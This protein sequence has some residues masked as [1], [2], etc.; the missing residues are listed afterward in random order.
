[1]EE[2]EVRGTA[3]QLVVRGDTIEYNATAFK[4]AENAMVEDLMKRLPGVEIA[5]DGKITINGQEINK[6]RVDG[7]KFFDGDIEMATKN[8][9]AEMIDKIQV[10]EQKSEMAQLTGFED[11]ET[12]R[13]INLTTKPNRRKGVFG[14]VVGGIGLDTENLIRYDA[15]SNINFMSGE[16]QTSVVAGANN[17]NTSRSRRGMGGWGGGNGITQTQNFGIKNSILSESFKFEAMALSIIQ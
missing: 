9:P 8:L 3:A 12:E 1:M 2:L 11:D 17:V 4:V 10:L 16:S 13:I 6:I 5:S 15:N 14:Y 7:K